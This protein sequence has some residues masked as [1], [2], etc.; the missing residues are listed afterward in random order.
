MTNVGTCYRKN[1]LPQGAAKGFWRTRDHLVAVQAVRET[2][3]THPSKPPLKFDAGAPAGDF[4]AGRYQG[5]SDSLA[6]PLPSWPSS[7]PSVLLASSAVASCLICSGCDLWTW[8]S[9]P[10]RT[11]SDT[12]YGGIANGRKGI[13]TI[14]YILVLRIEKKNPR[15]ML[16][17]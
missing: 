9:L 12:L 3:H 5:F 2:G 16:A 14:K 15:I 8:C 11:T 6:S 13:A 4:N 1:S 17:R 10:V 7:P